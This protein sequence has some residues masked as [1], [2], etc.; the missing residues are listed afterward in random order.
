MVRYTR[1]QLDL[2][3]VRQ[4]LKTDAAAWSILDMHSRIAKNTSTLF[5]MIITPLKATAWD[6][7]PHSSHT[8]GTKSV[9]RHT[10]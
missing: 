10:V 6:A 8:Y 3:K 2:C 9:K 5:F 1:A 7:S 4:E